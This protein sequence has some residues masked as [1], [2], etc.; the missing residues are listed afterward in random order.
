VLAGTIIVA[1][2][3]V[4]WALS[5]YPRPAA[6]S[7]RF[8]TLRAPAQAALEHLDHGQAKSAT[9]GLIAQLD[10][11]ERSAYLEQSALADIGRA[12]QPVFALA[13][14]DWRTTVGVIA[15]FPAREL[16]IP[17]LGVLYSLGDVDAGTY[18][19]AFLDQDDTRHDGLTARLMA[20]RNDD[21]SPAWSP[22]IA[23][24][25]MVFFALCSQC[26]GTLGAIYR[27]TR[28][29]K[30]PAFVFGYM[31]ALAW[32][33]AVLVYQIGSALGFGGPA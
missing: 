19:L 5:Y 13:G 12:V 20:T 32:L 16:I 31:T 10:N 9:E 30:W 24:S 1:T 26:M 17:T 18:D 7:E 22:L 14:F 15:A 8:D 6:I 29:W 21:G 4:I 23:L 28:T 33:M 3:V 11:A 25:V 2:S 27:E